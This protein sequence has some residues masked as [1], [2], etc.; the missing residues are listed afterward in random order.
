MT[1]VQLEKGVELEIV[2]LKTGRPD[3]SQDKRQQDHKKLI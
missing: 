3:S 2:Y 1:V